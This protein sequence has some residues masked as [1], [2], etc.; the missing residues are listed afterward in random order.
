MNIEKLLT[1]K[2]RAEIT[3]LLLK[4]LKCLLFDL[5]GDTTFRGHAAGSVADASVSVLTYPPN[6]A[7]E[8]SATQPYKLRSLFLGNPLI[9][10]LMDNVQ[11]FCLSPAHGDHVHFRH[12]T[13]HLRQ[14]I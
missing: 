6:H 12:S 14:G 13:L 3:V 2:G 5:Q 1:G 9:Q 8:L 10:Y 7:P 4:Q 11:S